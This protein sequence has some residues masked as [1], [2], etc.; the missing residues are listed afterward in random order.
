MNDPRFEAAGVGVAPVR[1]VVPDAGSPPRVVRVAALI[2]TSIMSG[3]GRQLVAIATAL[4]RNGVALRV[5]LFRRR[6]R[7]QP[8]LV[9]LLQR[10][11]VD[12]VVLPERGRLDFRMLRELRHDL[13]REQVDVL[14]THGYRPTLLAYLLR[15]GFGVRLPWVAFAHGR[16]AEN[17]K[18]RLYHALDYRLMRRADRVVVMS[19]RDA[20]EWR[21]FGIEPRVIYNAVIDLQGGLSLPEAESARVRA[22]P[23][24]RVGVIGRLSHEKGVDLFL[25]ALAIFHKSGGSCSAVI[26]GDGPARVALARQAEAHGLS[27]RVAFLG[28]VNPIAPLYSELDALVIPSRSE[29]LPNVMLE[30]LH[31]DVPVLAT[32]VG[33]IPEIVEATGAAILVDAGSAP[34]LRS[35]IETLLRELSSPVYR[36]GRRRARELL[37][38]ERRVQEHVTLYRALV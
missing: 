2:D 32:R 30:A 12:H 6:G 37:S 17:A 10:S 13:A 1:S 29:G 15:A 5:V 23:R 8:P 38:L 25:D 14:Q 34:A 18:V 21:R 27:D 28:D 22:L 7:P 24:P 33:G 35:G 36:A 19:Q 11:G 26:A 9:D 16:T 31:R 3:P 4:Q 20:T